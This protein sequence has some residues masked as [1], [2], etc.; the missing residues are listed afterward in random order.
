MSGSLP[1]LEALRDDKDFIYKVQL[2]EDILAGYKEQV[3]EHLKEDY[4]LQADAIALRKQQ[5]YSPNQT[6]AINQIL[7]SGGIFS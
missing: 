6:S 3:P 7:K 4:Y 2:R 1:N 5:M